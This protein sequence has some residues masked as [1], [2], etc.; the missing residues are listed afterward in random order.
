L[1]NG[2]IIA[3]EERPLRGTLRARKGLTEKFRAIVEILLT[4]QLRRIVMNVKI[5]SI[6]FDADKRLLD[7]IETKLNKLERFTDKATSTE[8]TLKLDKNDE[9]GNKIA[10]IEIEVPGESLVAERQSK[11]FE[12]SIDLCID[13]LKKQLEKYK[14]KR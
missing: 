1:K 5:Q 10:L 3:R 12:E 13:A 6:K 4:F 7:F 9:Q 11:S 8:V 2:S 14:D